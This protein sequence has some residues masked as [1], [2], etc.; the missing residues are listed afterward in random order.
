MDKSNISSWVRQARHRA[1]K[2]DIHNSLTI[3]E[4]EQILINY[5][6]K[7]AYCTKTAETLDHSF[8]LKDGAPNV[9]ANILPCCKG[10]K[11]T[12]KTND[13]VWMFSQGHIQNDKY[14]AILG[15][16]LNLNG[17]SELKQ[18][19]KKVTGMSDD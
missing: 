10:C 12:K 14:V 3:E 5:Q 9:Q 4:V 19:V 18:H 8:P 6:G 11:E 15:D 16:M 13:L 7:C 17:G 2:H 1:K